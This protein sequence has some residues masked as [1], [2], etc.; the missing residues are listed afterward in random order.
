MAGLEEEVQN[1]GALL[2]GVVV[3]EAGGGARGEGADAVE[4]V[5]RGAA[6][7]GDGDGEKASEEEG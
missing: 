1:V 3:Q 4:D 2:G 6:V 5:V 7:K